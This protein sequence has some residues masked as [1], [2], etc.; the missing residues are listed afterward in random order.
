MRKRKKYNM[1]TSMIKL[2]DILN[3]IITEIGDASSKKYK[4]NITKPGDIKID[5]G[6]S[7]RIEYTFETDSG[8]KYVVTLR[9][10]MRFIEI[11][12]DADNSY[13]LTNRGEMFKVMATIV[14]IIKTALSGVDMG[15]DPNTGDVLGLR[16]S[17]VS[18]GDDYGQQ[19]DNLYLAY[20]KKALPNI[21][22]IERV[23]TWT[24]IFFK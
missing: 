16:Y 3:G 15:S 1:K 10:R 21:K 2:T 13:N 19:R 24:Y 7:N 23:N 6:N 4:W 11:E 14:D 20:I 18:K 5:A 8:L 17:P 9:N 12:F 22:N